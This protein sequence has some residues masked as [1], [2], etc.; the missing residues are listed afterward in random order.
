M[1]ENLTLAERAKAQLGEQFDAEIKQRFAAINF[2]VTGDG[3]GLKSLPQYIAQE[4]QGLIELRE[5]Y[6]AFEASIDKVFGVLS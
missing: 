1:S 3:G 5:A 6:E 2:K 4:E